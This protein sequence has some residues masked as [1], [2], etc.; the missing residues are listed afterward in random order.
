[1]FKPKQRIE[2]K[3]SSNFAYAIGLIVSDGNLSKEKGRISIKSKD[4]EMIKNFK[5]ALGLKNKNTKSARGGEKTKKYLN[6]YFRDIRFYNFLKK[7]GLTPAKSK[8][9]KQAKIPKRFYADFLRGLFDGDGTFYVFWDRRWPNAFG[10]QIS[11]ASA[12]KPF[13]NWLK[14]TLAKF[15][16]VK[17]FVCNGDRVYN[18]RYVKGDS[19][20]LISKIYYQKDLLYLTRKYTKIKNALEFD[21][22]LKINR[23]KPR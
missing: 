10:Y 21:K 22:K 8:T 20:K 17:G 15:Y 16:G 23:K 18:I 1:M 12:S 4:E 5:S 9:I 6:V 3:W 7:I 2:I 13:I 11:F 14:E 19:I